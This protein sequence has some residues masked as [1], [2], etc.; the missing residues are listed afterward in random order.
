MDVELVLLRID[1]GDRLQIEVEPLAFGERLV[2]VGVALFIILIR[3][4]TA[5]ELERGLLVS[6][7]L[8]GIGDSSISKEAGSSRLLKFWG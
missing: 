7:E 4:V 1:V 6:E 3:K 5:G 2:H 8:I